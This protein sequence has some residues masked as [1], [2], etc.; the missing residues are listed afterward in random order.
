M[1]SRNLTIHPYDL[2]G[3]ATNTDVDISLELVDANGAPQ[4]GYDEVS[5]AG[6]V[7]AYTA[8]VRDDAIVIAVPATEGLV[9]A[10][11]WVFRVQWGARAGWRTYTSGLIELASAGGDLTLP[12]FLDLA[13]IPGTITGLTADEVAAIRGA[14][15]PSAANVFATIADVGSAATVLV[16]AIPVNYTPATADVEAH[17]AAID[18]MLG[19]L[20]GY[21]GGL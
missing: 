4:P 9:P 2:P 21:H 13:A 8:T 19:T 3:G 15:S 1:P 12:E 11:Y 5:G 20:S 14:A 17:L 16:A 7:G 6:V 18:V 10:L